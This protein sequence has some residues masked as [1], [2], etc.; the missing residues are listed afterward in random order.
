[1][2]E[3]HVLAYSNDRIDLTDKECPCCLIKFYDGQK[4]YAFGCSLGHT[5]CRVCKW[6]FLTRLEKPCPLCRTP[7]KIVHRFIAAVFEK[8]KGGSYDNPIDLT[9]DENN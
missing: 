5:V 1:M 2:D 4:V 7:I 3:D 8:P 6:R 9:G